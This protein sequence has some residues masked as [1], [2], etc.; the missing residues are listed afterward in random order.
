M[1]WKYHGWW[2]ATFLWAIAI[3]LCELSVKLG[4]CIRIFSSQL[5]IDIFDCLSW[6]SSINM[7]EWTIVMPNCSTFSPFPILSQP[8]V[9]TQ[10][11]GFQQTQSWHQHVTCGNQFG[12]C[13]QSVLELD[14]IWAGCNA[15]AGLQVCCLELITPESKEFVKIRHL[16]C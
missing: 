11:S 6:K 7:T 4:N 5:G 9:S 14:Y 2:L 13:L 15:G 3:W 8:T 16:A 1:S 12:L 10:L